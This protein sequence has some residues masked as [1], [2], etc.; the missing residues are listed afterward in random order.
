MSDTITTGRILWNTPSEYFFSY[1]ESTGGD[2]E[3][4][5][6]AARREVVVVERV[7]VMRCERVGGAG[8][9]VFSD[10]YLCI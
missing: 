8:V 10:G 5:E 1:A 9:C 4:R 7:S 3:W 2:A 6:S